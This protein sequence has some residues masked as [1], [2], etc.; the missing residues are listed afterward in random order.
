MKYFYRFAVLAMCLITG[1]NLFA[2]T[3]ISSIISSNQT[4]T[5][6]GSPYM[7]NANA[8]IE[9]NVTVVIEPGVSVLS[10]DG[11][12]VIIVDGKLIA[13]GKKDSVITMDKARF[14]F[15]NKSVD[16]NRSTGR[17][18]QFQYCVFNG[19]GTAGQRTIELKS[20]SMLVQNC[21]FTDCYYCITSFANSTDTAL[22]IIDKSVFRGITSA[23]GSMV[24]TSGN[25][26]RIE[27]SDCYADNM[28][29]YP[30]GNISIVKSTIRNCNSTGGLRFSAFKDVRLECNYFENFRYTMIDASIVSPTNPGNLVIRQNTF[31][32]AEQLLRLSWQSAK[33]NTFVVKENNFL[34]FNAQSVTVTAGSTPGKADTLDLQNNYWG[35]TTQSTIALGIRDFADDITISG[36]V[37]FRSFRSAPV[38]TC[39]DGSDI[40]GADTSGQSGNGSSSVYTLVEGETSLYPN[41]AGREVTLDAGSTLISTIK[42]YDLQGKLCMSSD[43]HATKHTLNISSLNNG[44]YL[45]EISGEGFTTQKRLMVR[46]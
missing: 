34:S 25:D 36:L 4:W 3:N 28:G 38:T 40:G 14:Q 35:T 16:Y 5:A 8:I 22:V 32:K 26:S 43:S 41:P 44:V 17:G 31:D 27:I 10:S 20:T 18:S 21:K 6:A 30:G 1:S 46:H 19:S 29:M 33:L 9:E 15:S 12:N 2:Q 45:L 39:T 23:Y 13:I 42:V 37:D 24:Y 11:K 7:L